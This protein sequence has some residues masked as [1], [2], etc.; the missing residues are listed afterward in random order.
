MSL[1]KWAYRYH[2]LGWVVFPCANK[3]PLFTA[4][5]ET[6]GKNGWVWR[7]RPSAEQIV[8]W[9]TRFPDAQIGLACGRLSGVTVIDIDTNTDRT[10]YPDFVLEPIDD[11]QTRW[12]I[13][14]TS[15]TGSGGRHVFCKFCDIGNSTK[16]IH[17]QVDIKS[18]GGYVIL[19]PS[20]HPKAQ[21]CYEWDSLF[22]MGVL[23][24]AALAAFPESILRLVDGR[25]KT[26]WVPILR[27]SGVGSRNVTMARIIGK[28]LVML[29]REE[30]WII[31]K[32]LN[33]TNNVPPLSER[34]LWNTFCSIE[35]RNYAR[36]SHR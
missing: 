4:F 18:E 9:W 13:S 12:V 26:D 27:G 15:I 24:L 30:T 31:A 29:G 33:L 5:A 10:K 34:E 22:P 32:S 35:K 16:D 19:P 17:P 2:E 25:A 21:K 8:D 3:Q 6:D 14:M 20:L 36:N 28:L 11:L 7:D 23:N 1:L